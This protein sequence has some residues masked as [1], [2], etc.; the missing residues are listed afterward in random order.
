[1]DRRSVW[2]RYGLPIAA[3]AAAALVRA[4]L[5][6]ILAEPAPLALF[7]LPVMIAALFGGI[8]PGLL[9]T[10]LACAAVVAFLIPRE[11][12]GPLGT[13]AL[14]QMVLFVVEGGLA[15]WLIGS[16]A[17]AFQ[18]AWQAAD[19]LREREQALRSS[20]ERYRAIVESQSEMVCRF[21]PDGTIV[22]VNGGYA[23]TR[24]T[25]PDALLGQNFWEFVPE[26]D[27][28]AVRAMLDGLTP[29]QPEARI[30]NR[31]EAADGVRW[32]LWTNRALSFGADG[33]WTEAQ[34]TGID[35]TDRKEAEQALHEANR[36]KNEFLAVLGHELRNPLAPLRSGVD[37]LCTEHGPELIE[38]VRRMMDR[39]LNHL[40]RLVEDLLDI[41]RISRGDIAL[42]WA[43][44]DL[45]GVIDAAVELIRPLVNE[46]RHELIVE[47]AAEAL[48]IDGDFQRLTQVVGNLLSNAAKYTEPGGRIWLQT[49]ATDD[50][51]ALV[52]VRD[53]GYGFPPERL[54]TLFEMFSQVPEHRRRTGGGGLGVGLALARQRVA[55]H[56][57]SIE[58]HSEGLGHGSEFVVRLPL[59]ARPA[60]A[61]AV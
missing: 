36:H 54:G 39:Q 26:E 28:T 44:L 18:F 5:A 13:S 33:R 57:G 37:L 46:R 3:V 61:A 24:G 48:P 38:N 4:A 1:M 55:L 25:T 30:E 15:S 49:T 40:V 17:R 59:A 16:R 12:G 51:R 34:S 58:A 45:H 43:Q 31:F 10:V 23:R 8:G 41:A 11:A 47:S 14:V 19:D 29:R 7:L 20:E 52:R 56:G 22:F 6:P 32:T 35:I 2:F 42:Q 9:A 53:T 60:P 50:G 27:R 21:R